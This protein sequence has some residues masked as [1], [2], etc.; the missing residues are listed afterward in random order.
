MPVT[1]EGV[2]FAGWFEGNVPLEDNV[3]MPATGIRLT[4]RYTAA[5][6]VEIYLQSAPESEEYA[7][8]ADAA[9]EG[10]SGYL[11]DTVDL[12]SSLKAPTGYKLN[13]TKTQPITLGTEGNVFKAYYDLSVYTVYYFDNQSGDKITASSTLMLYACWNLGI[14][15][16]NGGK[17]VLYVLKEEP[18]TI[19][20]ERQYAEDRTGSYDEDT[21][22]FYFGKEADDNSLPRGRVAAEVPSAVFFSPFSV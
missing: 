19:V 7:L 6:T 22:T 18:G 10:G 12:S 8:D 9:T 4:A 2:T 13:K 1:P 14:T 11:G 15:D 16:A 3:T 17:D 5:Y 21:R 20:L